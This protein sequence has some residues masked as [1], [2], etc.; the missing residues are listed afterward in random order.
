MMFLDS[1]V[2]SGEYAE[3]IDNAGELL[4]SFLENFADENSQVWWTFN[5]HYSIYQV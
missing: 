5:Q 2:S 3:R 4:E 1:P